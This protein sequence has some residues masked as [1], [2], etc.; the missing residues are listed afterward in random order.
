MDSRISS[1]F[2][3][4]ID[5]DPGSFPRNNWHLLG[6]DSPGE[7]FSG[8]LKPDQLSIGANR[9]ENLSFFSTATNE[10]SGVQ[11]DLA[12]LS[13][14]AQMN[15]EPYISNRDMNI[16]SSSF[17]GL[18]HEKL[19]LS[20][21]EVFGRTFEIAAS[22]YNGE[23]DGD[24]VFGSMEELESHTIGTLL[25]DDE[26]E[27]FAGVTNNF[28]SALYFNNAEEAED[29]D[30]FSSGGGMEL[31][32][33][34]QDSLGGY[35]NNRRA[36]DVLACQTGQSGGLASVAGEHPYGEHPSRTLF[37]RNI[38]SN[39]ED[40]ELRSLFEQYG[41]IRTLYTA[42]K[43]R[44]FVMISYYDIRAARSAM[45]ALQNKPLRRRKLDIHFSIPKDN[46]SD[47]D[48]NQGTL[49]VFNLD[50]SV[51][52]DELRQIFGAYGEVKEIRETPHKRHHKFIEFYDV[53]SAEAALRAL[54]RSDIAG[55]R[56]K[57]EPSR[58]G[59]ARRSLM[60]QLSQELEQEELR[61]HR[62]QAHSP[63]N[64]SPPV[65]PSQCLSSNRIPDNGAYRSFHRSIALST[66]A[67]TTTSK[68]VSGRTAAMLS[69]ISSPMRVGSS[70]NHVGQS[71][72]V[73]NTLFGPSSY[74]SQPRVTFHHGQSLPEFGI[75]PTNSGQ[76]S[77]LPS[78]IL[79][80][81]RKEIEVNQLQRAFSGTPSDLS[82]NH[83]AGGV[84][85]PRTSSTL[86]PGMVTHGSIS[87]SNQQ[88]IWGNSNPN[89]QH[90]QSSPPIL[91][92]KSLTQSYNHGTQLPA[93]KHALPGQVVYPSQNHHVGLASSGEP[94]IINKRYNYYGD[95][96]DASSFL[97]SS[98]MGLAR[99]TPRHAVSHQGS[100][101][102]V[103]FGYGM[104]ISGSVDYASPSPSVGVISPQQ[105]A[106]L[107]PNSGP[108]LSVLGSADAVNERGRSRRGDTALQADNK[109]QYQLDL[110]R[111][112][113][114][115]DRRTTLM[116]KNI[117]NKYTS[118]MLL[119]A[120]DEHHRGTYDFIY[121]PID[122]KNKCN[123]GYAF[124]NMIDPP[125]IVPFYQ[126]FNGKK[127]EKFNSEKVASLAYARIQGKAALVAHFQNSSLMNEDKRCRP[128][129]FHSEGPNVGDQEP[130][131]V[132]INVRTRPNRDQIS[133]GGTHNGS[134]SS[135]NSSKDDTALEAGY[136][137]LEGIA[138][139]SLEKDG[140][141]LG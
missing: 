110:D 115:E 64:S 129:L 42:C 126:A 118:K 67:N 128:I 29:F 50:V 24:E 15:G 90:A 38:N 37:V 113:R 48:V 66:N 125:C 20:E 75:G 43:H 91:W 51:S 94:N 65:N 63:L 140:E 131:P 96:P 119:A 14:S 34:S 74:G 5:G 135:S 26:D 93:Q 137:V 55:K 54:N 19:S 41:A 60:Q 123:V 35:M 72:Q 61:P 98:S 17:P 39:V 47:K 28:D 120:I 95:F 111:I 16:F 33:D 82:V 127:W 30:L 84:G 100:H 133:N 109:K 31:E 114:R 86:H 99:V 23:A 104:T 116:I 3:P 1:L 53:R 97:Q 57:L 25:P 58:P 92:S 130:F 6:K 141:G 52:N 13:A 62:Q 21:T 18:F 22:H 36:V 88:L 10:I 77:N 101:G 71:N 69:H 27:L 7:N 102:A 45:R 56:I 78:S 136:D 85:V 79:S 44:G 117:P 70:G 4:N 112:L 87:V 139:F 68:P 83:H 107:Y 89:T 134:P 49:V 11:P 40:T 122:F 9:K 106:R 46:P 73:E 59:G 103:N 108:P 76:Y 124:I 138:Q 81:V 80:K 105:R 2:Y 12:T 8:K 132:G 121:L 32:S